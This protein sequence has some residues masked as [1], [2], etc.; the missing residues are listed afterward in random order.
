LVGGFGPDERF[1]MTVVVF[2]V[3]SYGGLQ[4]ASAAMHPAA[5]L[6]F[7]EQG[8][9]ALDHVLPHMKRLLQLDLC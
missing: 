3:S 4:F 8:E 2:E 5:Q 9:D 1:G 7:S 6:F